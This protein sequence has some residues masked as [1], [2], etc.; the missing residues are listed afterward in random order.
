MAAAGERKLSVFCFPEQSLAISLIT[1]SKQAHLP[2]IFHS[3]ITNSKTAPSLCKTTT[4]EQALAEIL[5]GT[6]LFFSIV[7][8]R[9]IVISK[10]PPEKIHPPLTLD[11][12]YPP[13]LEQIHIY[14][15]KLTGSRL[16][17]SDIEGSTPVDI[18]R[19]PELN[20]R[21]S[22]TVAEKLKFLPSVSGNPTSTAVTNGGDGTATV[23]LRG[24]PASH[25]LVL[26]N[27]RRVAADGLEGDAIDLNTIA[28]AAID[29]IE[30]LKDGAS[31]IYGAD[32]IAGVVNIVMKKHFDG[33]L[34]E[35]SYGETSRGDMETANTSLLWGNNFERGSIFMTYTQYQQNGILSRDRDQSANADGRSWG[36][37]DSRS[38]AT[39]AARITRANGDVV[40]LNQDQNGNYLDSSDPDNFRLATDEDLYNY[41]AQTA[42]YVPNEHES[43][44]ASLQWDLSDQIVF[45]LETSFDSTIADT[46]L[47]STPYKSAFETLPVTVS[48]DNRYNP[49][50]EDI[51]DIR[52]RFVEMP[53]RVQQDEST[54][55][56]L[57]TGLEGTIGRWSWEA[58]YVWSQ[59]KA[60][61]KVSNLLDI[62]KLA[63]ALGPDSEC[64]DA[65]VA[66]N[67]FGAPGSISDEQ[68]DFV[69]TQSQANGLS[70][71]S[72]WSFNSV[73]PIGSLPAG[74]V[75]FASG[76]E[77]RREATSKKP[78]VVPGQG[79]TSG[80]TN[81]GE[82]TGS[83]SV[84]DIYAE[85]SLPLLNEHALV[86]SL[87]LELSARYSHYS[88]FGDTT[89]PK[90]GLILRPVG[91]LLLR[92]T[93]SKGFRAP[94]LTELYKSSGETHKRLVDPCS[95]TENVGVLPGCTQLTDSTRSQ[96]LT[97]LEGNRDLVPEKST[98]Y[99][100]GMVWSPNILPGFT[101]S[102]DFF[103][104][105]QRNV[106]DASPQNIVNLDA[107]TDAYSDLVIR[108]ED[109]EIQ[110]IITKYLN[111]GKR[112]IRGLDISSRYQISSTDFGRFAFAFNASHIHSYHTQ[113]DS[114]SPTK[115]IAGTFRDEAMDGLGAIPAWKAN[116]GLMWK[117]R[118]W[119]G[120]YTIYYV[121]SLEET[122]PETDIKR[123]L[124]SW[125]THDAQ[126]GYTFKK[127]DGVELL[128]G[129]DN[130][131]DTPPPRA[132][133]GFN[134]RLDTRTHELKGRYFYLKL[135]QHF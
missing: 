50:G 116:I 126:I 109:G 72:T 78:V 103:R 102:V 49:F 17:R 27:G 108:D 29:R 92:S 124:H 119:Q 8:Q 77:Y 98:S 110:K 51:T 93:W 24:L 94:S 18:L 89:N 42:A 12:L 55:K 60:I 74:T 73:V 28:P 46:Q 87:T 54:A 33:F 96:Y 26:I 32:A 130:L 117:S 91:G 7:E 45:F 71:L 13:G 39:P 14:G 76:F 120:T 36:G 134:D 129:I 20:L 65:C 131:F 62:D 107:N 63:Q 79:P 6:D 135:S 82:A 114:K 4:L 127:G 85:T 48:T 41:S 111:I 58:S 57:A 25:T 106:V 52:R 1:L 31:S 37:I 101:S 15:H 105:D 2:I 113:S 9:F 66:L 40:I 35:T 30:I 122:I 95:I 44:Y 68:I 90:V 53:P 34:L 118:D 132:A 11:Q 59:S 5:A 19:Q 99:T 83:R 121:S 115:N 88:D 67:L 104:I 43:L 3:E 133:S 125:T 23:T 81:F 64:V 38:S 16:A 84:F 47:A 128:A 21:G 56:R 75:D 69:A 70:K 112:E 80:G 86:K 97:Q 61:E 22:A 123:D 10:E 100:L